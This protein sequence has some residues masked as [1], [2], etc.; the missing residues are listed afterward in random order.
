MGGFAREDRRLLA[1]LFALEVRDKAREYNNDML[2]R[3]ICANPPFNAPKPQEIYIDDSTV[4]LLEI[5]P[6]ASQLPARGE[7]PVRTV[8]NITDAPC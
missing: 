2:R 7:R 5:S 4:S 6:L 8:I 3:N 1:L